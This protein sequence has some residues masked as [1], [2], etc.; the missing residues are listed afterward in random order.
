MLPIA[1]TFFTHATEQK[2]LDKHRDPKHKAYDISNLWET[3][4]TFTE[5]LWLD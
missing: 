1:L 3:G 2:T 5:L 4:A